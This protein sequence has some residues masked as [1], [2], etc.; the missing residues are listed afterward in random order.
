MNT[1][2]GVTLLKHPNC[3][4]IIAHTIFCTAYPSIYEVYIV[5]L[6]GNYSEAQSSLNL[7][8]SHIWITPYL[9]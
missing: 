2:N 3:H 6:Q 9:T 1:R 4:I 7:C 5:P 8:I